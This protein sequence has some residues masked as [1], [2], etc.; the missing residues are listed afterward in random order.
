MCAVVW[1]KLTVFDSSRVS[2]LLQQDSY[3]PYI[4]PIAPR[5]RI[6]LRFNFITIPAKIPGYFSPE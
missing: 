4:R 1:E 5:R 3:V 6:L 2:G